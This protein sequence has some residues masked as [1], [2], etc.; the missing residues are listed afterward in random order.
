MMCIKIR[1]C[2]TF[3]RVVDIDIITQVDMY[4]T[5][6]L[7]CTKYEASRVN[8]MDITMIKE[9]SVGP[10]LIWYTFARH[11]CDIQINNIRIHFG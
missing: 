2:L 4:G 7:L 6:T 11:D 1:N 10:D 3:E 8:A 5:Q 9:R